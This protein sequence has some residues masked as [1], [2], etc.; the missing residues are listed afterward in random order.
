MPPRR[1]KKQRLEDQSHGVVEVAHD[2]FV[3]AAMSFDKLSGDVMAI[4]F[5]FL[6]PNDIMS[7][8]LNKKMRDAAT[9]TMVPPT[10]FVVDSVRSYNAMRAMTTALPNLKQIKLWYLKGEHKY[11]DGEDPD[12]ERAAY[13]ANR[14]AHDIDIISNFRKLRILELDFAPLN[15]RY[16]VLFNFPLLQKLTIKFCTHLKWDLEMLAGMPVLEE[17]DCR[18]NYYLTGNVSSLRVLKD[19]LEKV[20]IDFC[21]R[22]E[23]NFMDLADFPHLKEL[24]LDEIAVRGDIRDI[25]D[26]DFPK[27]EQLTLPNTVCGGRSYEFQR[28]SDGPDLIRTL[29][30]IKQHRPTI[31]MK[32]WC[33]WLSKESPDW[34]D[35][36]DNVDDETPP[37]YIRFV[38]AG[39]RVG[40]QWETLYGNACEVNWLDPEPDKGSSH[41]SKYIQDLQELERKVD[42][43]R[44]FYQPP[45]EEEYNEL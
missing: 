42:D 4:I 31:L 34:Y 10:E 11:T 5:G 3:E 27:L 23:G 18:S 1:K 35:D 40:Y 13:P 22:V 32:D 15:G 37:F 12:E 6:H 8:R 20:I 29:Y 26:I 2:N 44:G 45:T 28:I 17:L 9:M 39:S 25:R 7:S 19:T 21:G 36:D 43:F 16:P 41:Y 14:T 33:A 38:E 30:L 24:N